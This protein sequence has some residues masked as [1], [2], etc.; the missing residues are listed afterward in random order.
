MF[1]DFA[2][3]HRPLMTGSDHAL[4]SCAAAHHRR[5]GPGHRG[6]AVDSRHAGSLPEATVAWLL[7]CANNVHGRRTE[8]GMYEWYMPNPST[9]RAR[10]AVSAVTLFRSYSEQADTIGVFVRPRRRYAMSRE[11]GNLKI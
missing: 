9:G 7:A 2:L 4:W 6:G 5:W 10:L 3:H 1:G 11:G 8:A